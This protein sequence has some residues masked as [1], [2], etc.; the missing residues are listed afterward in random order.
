MPVLPSTGTLTT[1]TTHDLSDT[2]PVYRVPGYLPIILSPNPSL[3]PSVHVYPGWV[4]LGY[5]LGNPSGA[6]IP[7]QVDCYA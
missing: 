4:G 2:S 6:F 5:L 7:I 1:S 3:R